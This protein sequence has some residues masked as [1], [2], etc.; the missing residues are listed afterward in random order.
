M[1]PLQLDFSTRKQQARNMAGMFAAAV[2]ALAVAGLVL[3]HRDVLDRIARLEAQ[4]TA[5]KNRAAARHALPSEAELRET[6]AAFDAQRALNMPWNEL[7]TA[8]EAVQAQHARIHLVSV[9]PNPAKGEVAINGEAP[10]FS[11]L[12]AYV[13]AL[14][15]QTVFSE[16]VLLSQRR[17]N[18]DGRHR[19]GFTL[20]A[21]WKR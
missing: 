12:M 2:L 16:V 9:Q 10:D 19:L 4:T 15:S 17:V 21:G 1:N 6:K 5:G 11:G 18:E 3:Q 7:L 13:Q 8:L 20:L 14:R